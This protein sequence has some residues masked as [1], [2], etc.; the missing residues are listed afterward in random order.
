MTVAGTLAALAASVLPASSAHAADPQAPG[1][2]TGYGF[3][4]C[5]APSQSVMDDWNYFSPYAAI[6]IY[7]SG[8]SRYCGDAYQPH[9][10]PEWVAT[11][12][13]HG[14]RFLPIH[15]GYQAP[16][17]K[18]NPES[19][20][21]KKH[22][23][24][25]TSTARSQATS[26]ANEAVAA[27]KKYGFP[28][29]SVT[30]LDIEYYSRSDT[31]CD[32]AVR[33]FVDAFDE[34]VHTLGFKTG[35]YSSGSAAIASINAIRT[36][37]WLDK[38]DHMWIAWTNKIADTD[39]GPY[40]SDSAWTGHRRIHQ[41]H[42]NVKQTYGGKSI[43][44]DKNFLDVGRG[45]VSPSPEL[46]CGVNPNLTS[47]P[48]LERGD[49]GKVVVVLQCVLQSLGLKKSV[50][51]E[52]GS[53]TIAAINA[54]RASKG[55]ARSGATTHPF[56]A[57]LLSIGT[58]PRVLKF[59][60]VS[61][62]VW[63]LQRSLRGAGHSIRLTGRFDATTASIVQAYR[64]ATGLGSYQTATPAVWRMLKRGKTGR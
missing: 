41:Y 62:D 26:D 11:N 15:V 12:A 27:L 19:R 55:W 20:V 64:R 29:G 6:G 53:G 63:R 9:L 42:N 49:T 17:F 45:S 5:V 16:C 58:E 25:T 50:T 36:A 23:S 39:G 10:S 1:S 18:N 13:A 47:W 43:T 31:S 61:Q 28:S 40:L 60:S 34:R 2:F 56:W 52:V 8:N 51:G 48:R 35:L 38:P 44:L 7:V 46:M 37:S 32:A 24:R 33:Q 3:D 57:A 14:W 21:Q 4:T 59:G 54:F 22:M 30:Y